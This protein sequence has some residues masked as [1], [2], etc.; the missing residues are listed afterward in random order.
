MAC[1]IV[2]DQAPLILSVNCH[3]AQETE[4]KAIYLREVVPLVD[5]EV[6]VTYAMP[7]LVDD[8]APLATNLALLEL[9]SIHMGC[10]SA[11][12]LDVGVVLLDKDSA[13]LENETAG[14][15]TMRFLDHLLV[16]SNKVLEVAHGSDG[17]LTVVAGQEL[18]ELVGGSTL[19][20][21]EAA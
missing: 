14:D 5:A 12:V 2:I 13:N 17:Q 9:D 10:Q 19:A 7:V 4:E 21:L 15:L 16:A 18:I 3:E 11:K 6:T 8:G 20:H 1:Q